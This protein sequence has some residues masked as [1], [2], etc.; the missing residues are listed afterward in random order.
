LTLKNIDLFTNESIIINILSSEF[1]INKIFTENEILFKNQK[2]IKKNIFLVKSHKKIT[3]IGT[4]NCDFG[5]SYGFGIIFKNEIINKYKKG[6]WNIHSGDLPKYRGRHPITAA[7]LNDEK[8]IGLSIHLINEKIDQGYLLGKIFVKRSYQD[9]EFSIKEKLL[10]NVKKLIK[11]A[12]K[13]FKN[14]NISRISKG[15]YYKPFF[16]GIV[17][18]DSKKF[19]Y[20]YIYNATKAQKCFDGIKINGNRYSDA[21]FYSKKKIGDLNRVIVCKNKKKLILVKKK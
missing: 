13:N 7:F 1:S 21:I 6:I 16:K 15:K 19:D 20:K 5:V 11:I 4:S 10:K 18:P 14:K 12:I 9:D 8:K 2:K 17:I 3:Q